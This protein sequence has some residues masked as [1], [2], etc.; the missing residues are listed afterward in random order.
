M[1]RFLTIAACIAA[2]PLAAS[3]QAY[4]AINDLTVVPL[5]ASSFEVI[6]ARGEGPRG[7]WCAAAEYAERRLGEGS[8][9]YIKQGRG[10]SRSL[11]GHK[12]VVFTTN[13]E[14]LSQPPSQSLSL[15]TTRIG[16]GL[17]V[18]HAIQFCRD[19]YD[20]EDRIIRPRF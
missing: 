11:A 3:A 7:I 15:T 10:P 8:R 6:E 18:D 5:N 9:V 17:P 20:R 4:R 13:A 14:T 2:F 16:V 19:V 1:T 12:A